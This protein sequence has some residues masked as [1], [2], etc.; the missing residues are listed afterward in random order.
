M[1]RFPPFFIVGAQRSGTTMLRLMLNSHPDVAIP[2]E[3]VFIVEFFRRLDAYGDLGDPRNAARLL[4]DIASHRMV[5][6]GGLITD[7][8]AI[9]RRPI[10]SYTDLVDAIFSTYAASRGKHRW[11]DKTPSY[12]TDID[13]LRA[14]FPTC[15]IVHLVRDGRDV[16]LSNRNVEWG[17]RSIPRVAADWRW[18]AL[19]GHKIGTVLGH[20]Y[21]LVRHEDLVVDTESTLRRVAAFLELPYA[22][23]MLE[24]P[25]RGAT[26]LP[27]ESAKWHRNSIRAPDAGLVGLW[28]RTMPRADRIIFE[29][30]AGDALEAFGYE[31]E[32][33]PSTLGSRLKNLYFATIRRY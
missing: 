30:C 1:T 25:E 18:K 3:S 19:V 5:K 28:K 12:V 4:D 14:M 24:Y 33:S 20:D 31:L 15:R 22:A 11:G 8:D 7:R 32:R 9:L 23:S 21:L 2:F 29:Q 16:A 27:V 17:I 26:D 6:K 10:R 13:V